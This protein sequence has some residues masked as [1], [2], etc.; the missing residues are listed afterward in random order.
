MDCSSWPAAAAPTELERILVTGPN[1]FAGGHL[2]RA[3]ADV[4][5]VVRHEHL[6]TDP[7]D[8]DLHLV[9]LVLAL[10]RGVARRGRVVRH[11]FLYYFAEA[12]MAFQMSR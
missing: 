6:A 3:L 9:A 7:V 4:G 12:G 8:A 5:D 11:Q 2:R 1:G 10:G